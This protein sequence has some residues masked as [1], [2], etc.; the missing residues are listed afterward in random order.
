MYFMF[1]AHTFD[2]FVVSC[3]VLVSGVGNSFGADERSHS[4]GVFAVAE[5]PALA[6]Y[7]CVDV[8]VHLGVD[9]GDVVK[10]VNTPILD[11]FDWGWAAAEHS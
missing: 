3:D 9:K 7:D 1:L 2:V 10:Q 5:H 8:G 4:L 11:C 6:H